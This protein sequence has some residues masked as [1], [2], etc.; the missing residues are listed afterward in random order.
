MRVERGF[1][2]CIRYV[3]PFVTS[4]S[5][6]GASAERGKSEMNVGTGIEADDQIFGCGND[7]GENS[8]L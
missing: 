3:D 4:S 1:I 5:S 7:D 8:S 6:K 2:R